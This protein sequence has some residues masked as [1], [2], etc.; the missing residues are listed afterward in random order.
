MA[1]LYTSDTARANWSSLLSAIAGIG[2]TLGIAAASGNL[3]DAEPFVLAINGYLVTWPAF[4]AIYLVWTH[5]AYSSRGPRALGT[6][7]RRE[8]AV[9]R[10]W[11]SALIGYGG[12]ASWTLM[13][14]VAAVFVTVLISQDPQFRG[15]LLY[16]ALGLLSVASSWALM[17][18][19]F[20]LQYL[21][22]EAGRQ[23]SADHHIEMKV[24]GDAQ[25]E[26]YLTL[27]ILLS[28]MAATVSANIRTR[29]AWSLVRTNVIFAF[30][31]NS[32]IVAMVVS[33]LL[34]SLTS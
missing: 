22:L 28:T 27:A 29:E 13:A 8:D 15:E 16:V 30:T 34:G 9:H 11:W 31:F 7:A 20:A 12:A 25:F 10:R 33:F 23:E 3:A 21:R 1:R 17:V 14:A 2:G 26:D 6:R 18:Y 32:V 5:V 24:E 4:T 19:A